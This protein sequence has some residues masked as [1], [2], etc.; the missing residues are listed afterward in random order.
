MLTY[1]NKLPWLNKVLQSF[2]GAGAIALITVIIIVYQNQVQTATKKKEKLF[3]QRLKLYKST[4]DLFWDIVDRK[5]IDISEHNEF[6]ANN[7]K[8]LLLAGKRVYNSF[9]AL[10]I[11]INSEFKSSG[12]DIIEIAKL[13][14][15]DGE[16]FASLFKKFLTVCREDLDIDDQLINPADDEQFEEFVDLSTKMI[17]DDLG[18]DQG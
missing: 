4:I 18:A 2:M 17:S 3:D 13:T 15:P 7:Q 16:Q 11:M 8:M 1:L 5:Q 6:K 10:L 12:K 9:N 14:N